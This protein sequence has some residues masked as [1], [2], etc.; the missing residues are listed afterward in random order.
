MAASMPAPPSSSAGTA[1]KTAS[2]T[3]RAGAATAASARIAAR[4]GVRAPFLSQA[5]PPPPGHARQ[6]RARDLAAREARVPGQLVGVGL[7]A[8]ELQAR[9]FDQARHE[10]L[11]RSLVAGDAGGGHPRPQVPPQAGR[12]DGLDQAPLQGA[13]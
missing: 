2:P 6:P 8:L 11:D 12:F 4:A 9:L 5:P 13:G 1:T 7:D 10:V 3:R